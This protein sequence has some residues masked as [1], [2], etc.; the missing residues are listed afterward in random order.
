MTE[1]NIERTHPSPRRSRLRRGLTAGYAAYQQVAGVLGAIALMAF[2]ADVLG[3]GLRSIVAKLISVWSQTIRP[4]VK[5]MVD[6]VVWPIN[7]FLN[8]HIVV[9]LR[10]RDYF[11]V[12]L[13]LFFSIN[14][15]MTTAMRNFANALGNDSTL[16]VNVRTSMSVYAGMLAA[17]I[18]VWP[19]MLLSILAGWAMFLSSPWAR[20]RLRNWGGRH[21]PSTDDQFNAFLRAGAR[22]NFFSLLPFLYLVLLLVAN[23]LLK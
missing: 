21:L 12:G 22:S 7:H 9:P 13:I 14:R 2:L 16:D 3:L 19:I 6:G 1:G 5:W 23:C 17:C 15:T 11:A 4:V 20:R 8:L 18:L 10:L